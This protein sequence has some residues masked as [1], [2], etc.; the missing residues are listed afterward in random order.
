MYTPLVHGVQRT[1]S[2]N[3]VGLPGLYEVSN[4]VNVAACGILTRLPSG[5][6]ISPLDFVLYL[7]SSAVFPRS[8]CSHYALIFE[9]P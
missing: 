7:P 9:M 4:N 3:P 5:F 6:A 1:P 8:A 2:T